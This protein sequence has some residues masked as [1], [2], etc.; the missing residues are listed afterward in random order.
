MTYY[1]IEYIAGMNENT[2]AVILNVV[3]P[4]VALVISI[5]S[6]YYTFFYK[7]DKGLIVI[8]SAYSDPADPEYYVRAF[9]INSGNVDLIL[10]DIGVI[11]KEVDDNSCSGG[12][13][14]HLDTSLVLSPGQ[15]K[16]LD[17]NGKLDLPCYWPY[18]SSMTLDESH[19]NPEFKEHPM[20]RGMQHAHINLEFKAGGVFA[21]GKSYHKNYQLTDLIVSR[22]RSGGIYRYSQDTLALNTT[23]SF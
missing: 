23:Y 17:L 21:T 6:L 16:Q 5:I 13:V 3:I 9:V 1:R 20:I 4:V 12:V 19:L 2:R 7:S 8:E 14:V 22:K 18:A 11:V 15:I 10:N